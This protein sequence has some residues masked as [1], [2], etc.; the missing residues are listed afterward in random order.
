MGQA[1]NSS[2]TAEGSSGQPGEGEGDAFVQ[3]KVGVQAPEPLGSV[4]H[5]PRSFL[6]RGHA[7]L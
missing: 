4:H 2:I 3:A 6:C 1:G 7:L 5:A